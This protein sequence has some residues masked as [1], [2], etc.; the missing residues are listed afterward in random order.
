MIRGHLYVIVIQNFV[1]VRIHFHLAGCVFIIGILEHNLILCTTRTLTNPLQPDDIR[2][3]DEDYLALGL[4][5]LDIIDLRIFVAVIAA[6]CVIDRRDEICECMRRL[7]VI[8]IPLSVLL[9]L[10]SVFITFISLQF[11]YIF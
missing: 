2:G 6:V 7:A 8:F 3:L 5:E 1:P 4:L 11:S 9:D 10:V